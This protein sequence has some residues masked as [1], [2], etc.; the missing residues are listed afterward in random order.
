MPTPTKAN[1]GIGAAE[2][3]TYRTAPA[4]S[5]NPVVRRPRNRAVTHRG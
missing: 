4:P 5:A 1:A 3:N 2:A